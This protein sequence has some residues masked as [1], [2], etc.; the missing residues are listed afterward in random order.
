MLDCLIIGDQNAYDL[1]VLNQ[2][3]LVA[4]RPNVNTEEFMLTY[5]KF[6]NA[7]NVIIALGTNDTK[8]TIKLLPILRTKF[9]T[10]V[11]WAL[12]SKD[13][14]F[15]RKYVIDLAYRLKD[16]VVEIPASKKISDSKVNNTKKISEYTSD[17]Q[18]A[19]DSNLEFYPIWPLKSVKIEHDVSS[20]V[21]ENNICECSLYS[22]WPPYE[23]TNIEMTYGE[24]FFDKS[25]LK[26]Y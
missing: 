19:I 25:F 24:I 13:S 11:I 12:P 7:K 5:Q 22:F 14:V 18:T 21:K 20:D 10:H 2:K 8:E 3:C 23:Y 1:S 6:P 4:Y 16:D 26:T 9:P 15:Q 17:R